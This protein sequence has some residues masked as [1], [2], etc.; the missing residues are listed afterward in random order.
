MFSEARQGIPVQPLACSTTGSRRIERQELRLAQIRI[1][2]NLLRGQV[3]FPPASACAE[4]RGHPTACL[5]K[6]PVSS[7]HFLSSQPWLFLRRFPLQRFNLFHLWLS[8]TT[9]VAVSRAPTRLI[10]RPLHPGRLLHIPKSASLPVSTVPGRTPAP[11]SPCSLWSPSPH[12]PITA[13]SGS[14]RMISQT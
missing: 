4:L 12:F 1:R 7:Y 11:T 9:G 13:S 6:R 5:E 3:E 2:P 10:V 8:P 14:T